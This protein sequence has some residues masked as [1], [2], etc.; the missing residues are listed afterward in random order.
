MRR[1]VSWV[2]AAV[3]LSVVV[4]AA[5]G[6]L[7]PGGAGAASLPHIRHV[8]VVMLENEGYQSAFAG[9]PNPYLGRTLP[10]QGALIEN[11]YGIAHES[12][13]NYIGLLGGQAPTPETQTDC[14]NY[15]DVTPGT[16]GPDPGQVNGHG[17]VYPA[18]RITLADQLAGAGL[19]W[20]GYMEDLM[21]D[22]NRDAATTCKAPAS[23]GSADATQEAE[24]GDQYATRHDPFMYYHSIIDH[25]DQCANVVPLQ[26]QNAGL[27]HDLQSVS[28][29]PNFSLVIPNLC[30]D[31]HDGPPQGCTGTDARGDKTGGLKAIDD[32][33]SVWVPLITSSPAYQQD[34]MLVL[35]FDEA[36]PQSD[37]SSCCHEAPGPNTPSA[38]G[39]WTG[40]TGGG[41]VGAVVLSP[42]VK[43]GTVVPTNAN[44]GYNHYSLLKTLEDIFHTTGGDDGKGHLGYASNNKGS[45]SYD[46]GAFGADVFTNPGYVPPPPASPGSYVFPV[47]PPP[48]PS[49][50]PYALPSAPAAGAAPSPTPAPPIAL[51]GTSPS[52]TPVHWDRSMLAALPGEGG[53]GGIIAV[54]VLV[55]LLVTGAVTFALRRGG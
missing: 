45:S 54:L 5:G 12:L 22:P 14:P 3:A 17:C 39:T 40:T 51:A 15:M 50:T 16:T 1:R 36:P 28:S 19:R 46:P 4:L 20:K 9:N 31:G 35:A 6:A 44:G 18:S 43:P 48:P 52:P 37:A 42:F 26:S 30:D 32:W 7:L 13:P 41:K 23:G 34:G 24:A 10:A 33:L 2:R 27:S 21:S 38:G 47:P 55:P 49:S 53:S 25:A 29:T 11:Y 8:W